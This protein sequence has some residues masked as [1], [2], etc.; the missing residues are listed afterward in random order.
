MKRFCRISAAAL[1]V[2][3]CC[4]CSWL[5]RSYVSVTP[6]QVGYLRTDDEPFVVSSYPQLRSSL[7]GMVDSGAGRALM[8][9]V[10]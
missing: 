4:G 9:L 2:L 3:L 6:Q 8:T 1:A 5:D 10:N 7:M